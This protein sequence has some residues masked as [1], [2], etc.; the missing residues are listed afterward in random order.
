MTGYGSA[1]PPSSPHKS[2]LLM[3]KGL[4]V[5]IAGSVAG[6][7]VVAGVVSRGSSGPPAYLA[8]SASSVEFV[9]WQPVGSG[10]QGTIASDSITGTAPNETFPFSPCRL[11]GVSTA[12]R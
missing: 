5:V 6:G 9:T 4:V 3:H 2:W 1:P 10:I 8:S 7:A 12:A 11:P